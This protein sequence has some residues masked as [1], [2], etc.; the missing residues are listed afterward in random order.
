M[1]LLQISSL[2][3]SNI[4]DTEA[5]ALLKAD[6]VDQHTLDPIVELPEEN[7]V[8]GLPL[9]VQLLSLTL[10]ESTVHLHHCLH[11]VLFGYFPRLLAD[12]GDDVGLVSHHISAEVIE[13]RVLLLFLLLLTF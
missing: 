13:V 11:F 10:V 3:A 1:P 8:T 7:D 9:C 4:E 2:S 5:F 12:V 6:V